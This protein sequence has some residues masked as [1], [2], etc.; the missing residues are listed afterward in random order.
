M[1]AFFHLNRKPSFGLLAI[2]RRGIL[3]GALGASQM[4]PLVGEE[5]AA[6]APADAAS[7]LRSVRAAQASM[8]E[9]FQ[10][11]LRRGSRSLA[12]RMVIDG[13]VLRF[14]F[15]AAE[16]KD[17]Q[18]VVI[19]SGSFDATLEVRDAAGKLLSVRFHEEVAGMGISYEDL[20]LR[21]LF[22]PGAT[23]EGEERLMLSKC[24]KI[25]V[26]RPKASASAYE[27]VVLWVS[28]SN[29]AFLKSEAYGEHG[30]LV[31]RLTVRSVQTI[32][33]ATALKQLRAE[34]PNEGGDPSYLDV[35]GERVARPPK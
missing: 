34:S 17:P 8:H 31:R 33:G 24:W 5:A 25:R 13:P 4:M 32:G 6:P 23:L 2:A 11:K 26:K 27:E 18:T 20:A 1:S 15:P 16:G 28:Q 35:E 9:T 12:Y 19:R 3:I 10:G 29:G 21:F 14:E 22:W 7:I 30:V